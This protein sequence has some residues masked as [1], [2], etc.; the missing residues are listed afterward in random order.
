MNKKWNGYEKRK[1]LRKD[2]EALL[3]N[4]TPSEVTSQPSEVLMHELMV[5]KIELEMQIEE[6]RKSHI[7]MEEAR[8]RY[9]DIYEFAPV[10]YVTLSRSG[11]INEINLTGCAQLGVERY[12][13]ISRRFSNY[14]APHD[15]DRWHRLFMGLMQKTKA[16][17]QA[18]DLEMMHADGSTLYV[19]LECRSR[20]VEDL[21]PELHIVLSDITRLKLAEAELRI[22]ANAFESGEPMFVTDADNVILQANQAFTSETGYTS[23]EVTGQTL[24]FLSSG[25]HTPE[26]YEKMRDSTNLTGS[27]EGDIWHKCKN[28][29][30]HLKKLHITAV[31]N[32]L[33]EVT[34]YV[35]I[36][37]EL[38]NS[39]RIQIG[40]TII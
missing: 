37:T 8:D 4:L 14:V 22:M 39:T 3:T 24:G 36:F 35:G 11:L 10:G 16:E 5:H 25:R 28:G 33:D 23:S 6:L 21:V 26:F 18:V 13:L 19:R 2:A 17:K 29:E 32:S 9:V 31:K 34:N 15:R 12:R 40:T 30:F 7:T 1:S 38:P 27:W 20:E